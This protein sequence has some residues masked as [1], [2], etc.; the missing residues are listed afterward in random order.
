M[1][2]LAASGFGYRAAR[3]KCASSGL[4][5]SVL[6]IG[7]LT[8]RQRFVI[9]PL[10]G[11]NIINRSFDIVGC[12]GF[13]RECQGIEAVHVGV[14]SNELVEVLESWGQLKSAIFRTPRNGPGRI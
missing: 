9:H 13:V 10:V 11:L 2:P 3:E 12:T 1:A 7:Q 6:I 4:T 5:A 8:S 14:V